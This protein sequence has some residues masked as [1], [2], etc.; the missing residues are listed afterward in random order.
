MKTEHLLCVFLLDVGV[1]ACFRCT[2]TKCLCS[3]ECFYTQY[4]YAFALAE[5]ISVKN[6]HRVPKQYRE[7]GQEELREMAES[8]L[9]ISLSQWRKMI[10]VTCS[11]TVQVSILQPWG[12][13]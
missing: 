5:F 6:R 8:R 11:S 3:Y 1:C 9:S 2:Q 4:G 10:T 12:M 13:A 7:L